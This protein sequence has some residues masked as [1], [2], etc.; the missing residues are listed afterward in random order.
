MFKY[1]VKGSQRGDLVKVAESKGCEQQTKIHN[2]KQAARNGGKL[3]DFK[4]LHTKYMQLT[5]K[6]VS[7]LFIAAIKKPNNNQKRRTKWG[8]F[9]GETQERA[10]WMASGRRSKLRIFQQRRMAFILDHMFSTE[11]RS[12]L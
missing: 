5:E 12:G 11:L 1:R 6:K 2:L 8:K 3:S 7:S 10:F 4:K 9:Q